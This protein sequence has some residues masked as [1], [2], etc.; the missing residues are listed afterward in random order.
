MIEPVPATLAAVVVV[1]IALMP[2]L[3]AVSGNLL[4]NGSFEAGLGENDAPVAWAL[5]GGD[6]A[7]QH[8]RLIEPG[9]VDQKAVLIEDGD[10]TKE[11]G[12]MQTCP[13]HPGLTYQA[14]VMVRGVA[15]ASSAGAYIQLRFLPSNEY[16][17][18]GLTASSDDEFEEVSVTATAP[19]DTEQARVYLYT[20]RD[21]TPRLIVDAVSLVSGVAPPPP[22]PPEPI[23]P[24]YTQLKELYLDTH[25]VKDGRSAVTI[26]APASGIYERQ[27]ARIQQA[28]KEL[29]GVTVP[30]ATDEA[31]QAAAPMATNLI[32][33]GNRSTNK[34]IEELYNRY[35]TLLDLRY[36]GPEGYVVRTLH[37]PFGDGHNVVFV[38]G[39]DPAGVDAASRVFAQKLRGAAPRRGALSIGRLAEIKL[40][41]DIR[42]PTDVKEFETWEASAG[43]RSVGYFGWNSISKHMAMYYM[44]GR[45]LHAREALRLAFPDENA[46]REIAEIDGER[47]E[48]KDEPLSGPYHYNAHMM[49]LFWDLIEESPPFSDEQRLRVTN[50]FAK[51][52]DHRKGEGIYGL[53]QPPERVGSRHGQWSAISLYCLGRYFQKDYPNPIWAQCVR[54]A[55]LHF[56]PLYKH[57]WVGGE[58]DNL[59]WYNTGIA[60][61][62]TYM[63]LSADRRPLESGS[64][65]TLLRGQEMLVSGRVPDWALRSASIGYLHKAAHLTGD[66]RWL[67]YRDRTGVDLS[68]FRLGQSF[69]P[70]ESIQPTPP[71]DLVGR[72]SI[73]YLPKPMWG[74]RRSGL[75]LEQSF[76][77]GSFR[78]APDA[79]GDFVLIDGYNGASRNPYHTFAVLELRIDGRT[80]LQGYR[81]QVLTRVDGLVE[82]NIAMNA[83]LLHTEVI[84]GAAVAIAEVPDAAYCNWRRTLVQRIGKYALVVD[85]LAF[86]T[87]S[88]NVQVQTQW[89]TRN[90]V[91]DANEQALRIAGAGP[92][93][94]PP[95]WQ[96]VRALDSRCT[97]RPA[98]EESLRRLDELGIMLLRANEP[99]AH[100]EMT[101]E[102][103]EKVAGAIYADFLNYLDRGVV[104][105][106]LDGDQVGDDYDN[107]ARTAAP[108]RASL[109]RREL[110][111]GKHRLRVEVVARHP[112]VDKCYVG[113]VGL[114]IRADGAPAPRGAPGFEIRPSDIVQAGRT[115][116][117]AALEWLGSVKRGQHLVF[118]S[119]LA[120][121][122]A[123]ADNSL[124]CLR[125]ADNAAAL[126]LPAP[127][128]AVVGE[129]EGTKADLAV[130]AEGH[131]YGHGLTRAGLEATLISADAPV[132]VDWDFNTGLLHVVASQDCNLT[133]RLASTERVAVDGKPADGQVAN[134]GLIAFALSRGRHV[135]ERAKP[136]QTAHS[137]TSARLVALLAQGAQERAQLARAAEQKTQPTAPPLTEAM[138]A[139]VGGNVVDLITIPDGDRRL[140]CAAEGTTVHLLT[141]DGE[142]VRALE[143]DGDVRMLR[144][145]EEHNLLLVGC[146]DEQVIAFDTDGKRRWVFTSEM[147]PAVFR[148]AKTY[149]FKS[150]PRHSGIH[151]LYTGLF[152]DGESQAF[153]GSACTLEILDEHGK[154][155]KRMPQ[156][157]GDVSTF[158]MVPGPE[159]SLNLLAARKYNGTNTVR[160]INNRKLEPGDRGFYTVPPGHTYVPGWSSMNRHHLFY[161]DLDGD[162]TGE[163]VSETNGTWNRV[164][165]WAVDGTPLYDAS[166]GPGA[167]MPAKN[168][169]DLDVADLDGDGKKEIIAATSSGLVVALDYQCKKRWATRLSG[170]P[171]VMKCM[172]AADGSPWIVLG[173]EDGT[174]AVLDGAGKLIRR[175]M[176]RGTPTCIESFTASDDTPVVLLA[177]SNGEVKGFKL[178]E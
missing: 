101:F 128:V 42:V 165:V 120:G 21:S 34:T 9:A 107:Y 89:E 152:I 113:L 178:G 14:S 35:Y 8:I 98:G 143:A 73:N 177:T 71:E 38:G 99:G 162:G 131:L 51:Q 74:A 138:A 43:Y 22:P 82:P 52:L 110:A 55:Q 62:F 121:Q 58:S 112:G 23:P 139:S 57:A 66:G 140:I 115:G 154:L 37:N 40:G 92:A 158:A 149:W 148:A 27:A 83:G 75:P 81:N 28:I 130:L 53:T 91:W 72:W 144:W 174:V 146:A 114:S 124:A 175:G 39:S 150:D 94:V 167:R 18:A 159:G 44:T 109:A 50:A 133:L 41:K 19:P 118:F 78:S 157:W 122:P 104:R 173:C 49:I 36:P 46:R 4:V 176:V 97:S 156:F 47:I 102:L 134:D 15:G 7:G 6:G 127:A 90:G 166:F 79:S 170:P 136:E 16:A 111:A 29:T 5:Y 153:V 54:G 172:Q 126:G 135:F 161:E 1:A 10:P 80:L 11:I 108:G 132:D 30:I 117:V 67:E 96:A 64:V 45:E 70:D 137:R 106:F 65:H 164:T 59:F 20:H 24:V 86:R 105:I 129:Y 142:R 93:V 3:G 147:D 48:N 88:E 17:Q 163:V 77:F 100:I 68:V 145:W 151:G 169:R 87:D 12:L 123:D 76:M 60:P 85:D 171:T 95:G 31:P 33:L 160:I 116:N 63:L 168:M 25:L 125:L 84:G 32:A 13:A 69:W 2:C 56:A 155:I 119:L 103:P 26:V 61:I 141:P